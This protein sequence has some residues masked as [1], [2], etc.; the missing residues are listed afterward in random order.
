MSFRVRTYLS[1]L[2]LA[3]V[4]GA[5]GSDSS[6]A[7]TSQPI[8]LDQALTELSIPALSAAAE[9]FGGVAAVAPA[10]VPSRC[11]FEASSQSFVCMPLTANGLTITQ[12]YT[13][14]SASG[15]KQPAFDKATTA[16]VRANTAVAGTV[17]E[18]GTSL[19]IDGQQELTLS[20][21]LTGTHTLDG[22]STT[23]ISGTVASGSTQLPLTSTITTKIT[24]LVLPATSGD[25]QKWPSSGTI[26]IESSTALGPVT[27]AV[28][29]LTLTFSGTSTVTVTI[30]GPGISQTCKVDLANKAPTC[31]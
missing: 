20:G 13:L 5:C 16:S 24:G 19:T 18:G 1:A 21:L 31:G 15:A 12:S 22:T 9:S 10:L 8:T 17:L 7:P 25:G 23:H 14:F 6:V 3:V 30:V 2:A 4:A 29:R 11:A 28:T 27:P 26:V